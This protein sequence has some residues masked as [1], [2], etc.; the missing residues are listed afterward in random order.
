MDGLPLMREQMNPQTDKAERPDGKSTA[1]ESQGRRSG[2]SSDGDRFGGLGRGHRGAITRELIADVI[3]ERVAR[4][5]CESRD[6]ILTVTNR[7]RV[8]VS[9][10]DRESITAAI[11]RELPNEPPSFVAD[12]L[13]SLIAD[14]PTPTDLSTD[15]HLAALPDV[16][17]SEPHRA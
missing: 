7:G 6:V 11:R 13:R 15:A 14:L 17:P 4:A 3:A 10:P 12:Y 8:T 1:D 2:S 16:S 9:G 5:L